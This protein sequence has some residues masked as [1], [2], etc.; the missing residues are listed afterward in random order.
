MFNLFLNFLR[1]LQRPSPPLRGMDIALTYACN[2]RC[3]HCNINLLKDPDRQ[4]LTPGEI[5]DLINR[6]AKM[7][8]V[9]LT[10]TGGEV[11]F[12]YGRLLDVL[13]AFDVNRFMIHIQ[14]NAVL[15]DEWK[16]LELKTRGVDKFVLSWD[17]YHE[18]GNWREMLEAR[19]EM[20]KMIRRHGMKTIGVGVAA[21]NVIYTEPFLKTVEKAGELGVMLTLNLP[22]PLGSWLGNEEVLLT[23]KDQA[24]IRDLERRN[25]HVRL[26]F[27]LNFQSYGC[28]AFSERFHVNAY[29]DVQPC[30]FSQISFGNVKTDN[31]HDI[32]R[33]G[34]SNEVFNTFK[35]YCPPAEDKRFIYKYWEIMKDESCF[36][37]PAEMIFDS[38]GCLIPSRRELKEGRSGLISAAEIG[39]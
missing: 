25:Y 15:L 26:D 11:M 32:R 8:L 39:G 1:A 12:R 3:E 27:D 31:L 30:T 13:S 14:T 35:R 6:A 4:Y 29:G 16:I 33:R 5:A 10:L 9:N 36:P 18:T 34:L 23:Q 24:Y 17:P 22:V 37:I 21:R 7:G 19:V 38:E 20:V 2:L 28:P